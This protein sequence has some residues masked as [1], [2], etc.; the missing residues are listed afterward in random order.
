MACPD[1]SVLVAVAR[2][3]ILA[4]GLVTDAGEVRLNY[5]SPDAKHRGIS[6]ALLRALETRAQQRGNVRCRLTST[7]TARRFYHANGYVEDGRLDGKFGTPA[8]YAMSKPLKNSAAV[9]YG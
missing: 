4:V 3:T 6:R 2:G 5:V 1:N 9:R 8:S 7:A